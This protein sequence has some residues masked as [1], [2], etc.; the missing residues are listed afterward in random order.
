M[1]D[2]AEDAHEACKDRHGRHA[3]SHSN[4]D[5]LRP[6]TLTCS[7]VAMWPCGHVASAP[8]LFPRP[9]GRNISIDASVAYLCT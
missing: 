7:Y 3:S 4:L 5:E 1:P 2:R 6:P 8:C 9:S